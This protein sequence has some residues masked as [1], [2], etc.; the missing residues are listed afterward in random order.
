[1]SLSSYHLTLFIA[2]EL[3]ISA[4]FWNI[5]QQMLIVFTTARA[6]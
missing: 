2:I 1:M 4:A 6:T 5:C 3:L